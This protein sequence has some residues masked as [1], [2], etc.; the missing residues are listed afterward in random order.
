ME[1]YI[2]RF[3]PKSDEELQTALLCD[4]GVYQFQVMDAKSKVSRSGNDM[5]ELNLKYWDSEGRER[6][7]FDYLL[8]SMAFKLKHFCKAVGLLAEYES[9]VIDHMLL[10]GKCGNVE[11]DVQPERPKETGGF[12]PPKNFVKDY[13]VNEGN[14]IEPP[15]QAVKD[16]SFINDDLPF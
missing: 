4:P 16:E 10:V 15:K 11:I 6:L 9:G 3:Q 12:W 2:V 13:L 8:E 7:V 14:K 1:E 5:I